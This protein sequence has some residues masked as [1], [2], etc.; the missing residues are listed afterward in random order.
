MIQNK[1]ELD[2]IILRLRFSKALTSQ[3]T[4]E[5]D[6]F[7]F[8]KQLNKELNI[9][10]KEEYTNNTEIKKK[11]QMYIENADQYFKLKG[12][13]T[14]WYDFMGV[15]TNKF[16]K[17]KDEWIKF[18]KEK[19]VSSINDYKEKCK[20]YSQLPSNPIDFYKDFTSIPNELKLNRKRR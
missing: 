20:E 18:C 6:E 14:D 9:T 8:V 12:V 4:E 1:S 15:D 16:L 3:Y 17:N 13:W 7:N 19:N 2:K 11:H 10:D 5:Q